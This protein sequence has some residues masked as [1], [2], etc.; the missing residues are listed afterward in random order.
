MKPYGSL[1]FGMPRMVRAIAGAFPC[2]DRGCAVGVSK[3]NVRHPY[4]W[5]LVYGVLLAGY[6][7]FT[8]L[9]A[10]VLPRDVVY[11][12]DMAGSDAAQ[13]AAGDGAFWG[14]DGDGADGEGAGLLNPGLT[15]PVVTDTSYRSAGITIEINTI[16]EYD[17]DIYVADVMLSSVSSLRAGLASGMFG[18]NVSQTTSAI[19]QENGAILAVNGDYYGFR[20]RGF[21]M[22]NGYLY[23]DTARTSGITDALVIGRDGT[24]SIVDEMLSDAQELAN[25]ALHIFS[26]GPGLIEDGVITVDEASEVEQSM[27][28]NPRTAIGEI[29]PLHYIILVSD[30]RTDKSSGLTLLQTAGVMKELGCRTAYN[31]D[32]GGSST[33]WFMGRVVNNPTSGIRSGERSVSDII[34]IGE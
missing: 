28:S 14:A 27:R 9:D 29:S 17:T 34:Y 26:F 10:F 22:R 23:R 5:A 2:D 30:G 24:F 13:G 1:G 4:A 6:A 31:L 12:G 18:R 32:G 21:V 19:A 7:G 11:V 15:E 25:T 8:L 33:M 16:R 20:D 3:E